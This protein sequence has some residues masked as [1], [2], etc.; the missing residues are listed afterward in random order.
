MLVGSRST[1]TVALVARRRADPSRRATSATALQRRASR[2]APAWTA[3]ERRQ[4]AKLVYD[5]LSECGSDPTGCPA[6]PWMIKSKVAPSG[7]GGAP[8]GARAAVPGPWR[9]R[10]GADMQPGRGVGAELAALVMRYVAEDVA[11]Y[12]SDIIGGKSERV[13]SVRRMTST[14]SQALPAL[15]RIGALRRKKKRRPSRTRNSARSAHARRCSTVSPI[16][17]PGLPGSLAALASPVTIRHKLINHASPCGEPCDESPR[18]NARRATSADTFFWVLFLRLFG[19]D[20]PLFLLSLTPSPPTA[21]LSSGEAK[22]RVRDER[23]A[24]W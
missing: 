15:Y 10:A 2:G 22:H 18:S 1:L 11:V 24:G 14:L 23:G 7:P 12:N 17:A 21:S 3:D 8:G 6:E 19:A 9:R 20:F 4:R 16:P 5:K 13:P